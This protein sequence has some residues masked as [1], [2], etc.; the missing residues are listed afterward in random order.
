VLPKR[1]L[2][3]RYAFDT[4]DVSRK[5]NIQFSSCRWHLLGRAQI[6]PL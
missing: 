1:R 3:T 6:A 4:S 2:S 5:L